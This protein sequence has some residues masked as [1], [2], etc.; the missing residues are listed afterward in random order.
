MSVIA[1]LPAAESLSASIVF[2]S[3]DGRTERSAGHPLP[4]AFR[5]ATC[6]AAAALSAAGGLDELPDRAIEVRD[7]VMLG[8]TVLV[9][10]LLAI[11]ERMVALGR[12][13]V[14]FDTIAGH[15]EVAVLP[16]KKL[17]DPQ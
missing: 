11:A 15:F 7:P 1:S 17:E 6:E 14:S 10:N 3:P 8:N 16:V 9:W 5:L 2:I 13:S 4:E 12:K